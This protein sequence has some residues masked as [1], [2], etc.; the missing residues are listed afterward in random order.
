MN[1]AERKIKA[2]ETLEIIENG[3]YLDAEKNKINI[4][5]ELKKAIDKTKYFT[6]SELDTLKDSIVLKNDY[7][8]SF[9]VTNEDSISAIL[10]LQ[11]QG[12]KNIMCL[13]FASAKNPG[14]G[15]LNGSLAQE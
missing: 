8:T 9:S 11:S 4:K 14:G 1:R 12:Q 10:R 7:K 6:S 5:Q 15:F 13:N 3:F 2:Q